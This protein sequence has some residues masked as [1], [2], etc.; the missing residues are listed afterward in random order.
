MVEIEVYSTVGM[1]EYKLSTFR[2]VSAGKCGK[3]AVEVCDNGCGTGEN[4][5]KDVVK[6]WAVCGSEKFPRTMPGDFGIIGCEGGR[7]HEHND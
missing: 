6:M 4:G 3:G 2:G 5:V 7:R 1:S